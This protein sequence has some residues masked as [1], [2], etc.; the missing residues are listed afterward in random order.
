MKTKPLTARAEARRLEDRLKAAQGLDSEERVKALVRKQYDS[1][2]EDINKLKEGKLG[3]ITNIYKM[4][5]IV[6]GGKKT[7]QEAHAVINPDTKE[8]V[9]DNDEIKKATLTHCMNTF[10]HEDPHEDVEDLVNLVNSVHE[11]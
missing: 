4:K 10:R 2:Q 8:I 1:M 5:D 3:R 11:D 9:V 6:A 7:A